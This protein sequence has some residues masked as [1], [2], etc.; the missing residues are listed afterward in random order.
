MKPRF[1]IGE[2]RVLYIAPHLRKPYLGKT[3]PLY[4]RPEE[5]EGLNLQLLRNV[6]NLISWGTWPAAIDVQVRL[7]PQPSPTKVTK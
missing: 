1:P 2:Y 6:E 4:S 5:D 3:W 7:F